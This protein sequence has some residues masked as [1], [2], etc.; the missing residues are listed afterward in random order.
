MLLALLP[1]SVAHG[2]SVGAPLTHG[3]DPASAT[4]GAEAP[5]ARSAKVAR[6]EGEWCGA[7]RAT[8]D[9][10]NETANGAF[11]YHAVYMLPADGADRFSS[12]ASAMQTDALQASALLETEYGRAIRFDMGTSC[13]PQYLDISVVRMTKT[14]AQLQSLAQTGTGTFEAVGAALDA[15]GLQTIQPT[16]SYARAAQRTRNYVVW[17]D[18]PAP[19]GTCGQAAIY[20]DPTRADDNLNNFGG[21]VA[22]VFQNG[23][24]FCSSNAVRHEIGH[25]LGALQPGAPHAFDGSHCNDAY[26]DTMCYSSAPRVASGVRGQF[27]DWGNDD[28]WD[29]PAGAPLPWWTVNL[30]RFLCPDATCNVTP[31]AEPPAAVDPTIE[32]PAAKS[33]PHGRLKLH[34]RRHGSLWKLKIRAT[35]SGRGVVSVRCRKHRHSSVRTVYRR[36]TA[37]PSTLRHNVRCR[38]SRPKARLRVAA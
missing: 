13:G 37:L 4:G 21:K 3:P 22:L 35:G 2:Q 25:N 6:G 17:L 11:K 19:S 33:H 26:E 16:D 28:Y 38:A 20:D 31:G 32:P 36:S 18:G 30:N 8:D 23:G 7:E 5:V 27:F 29:P 15:A 1:A 24:G 12:L 9:A 14:S 10:A 34:V